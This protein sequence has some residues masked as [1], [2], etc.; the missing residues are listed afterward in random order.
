M[1]QRRSYTYKNLKDD[2]KLPS[3]IPEPAFVLAFDAITERW[4][5]NVIKKHSTYREHHTHTTVYFVSVDNMVVKIS[6]NEQ[7]MDAVDHD[8]E[9]PMRT[10]LHISSERMEPI[11]ILMEDLLKFEGACTE[12]EVKRRVVEHLKKRNVKTYHLQKKVRTY[13]GF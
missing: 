6:F 12:E 8:E 9:M 10:Q 11:D 1:K 5:E 2:L 13:Y 7:N 4:L 3:A